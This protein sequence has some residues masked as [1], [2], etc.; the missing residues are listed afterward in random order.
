MK[1]AALQIPGAWVIDPDLLGDERGFFARTFCRKEFEQHGL[2]GDLA[3]CNVSFNRKRGTL[4]GMHYQREPHQEAKL[5]R[6]TQG[7]I[8]DVVLDLRPDSP[9]YLGWHAI[10]LN[11]A[12]RRMLYVPEG[13]AHGFM[14]LA[15]E[16]EV[17][18]QMAEF[19]HPEC[20]AGVRWDDP[21]FGIRWPFS[22]PIASAKDLSYPRFEKNT[23]RSIG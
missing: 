15:D 6:C 12:N 23:E 16:S 18:Y 4:R 8:Y 13:C 10:E 1:F 19:Y 5:V 9:A 21:A 2:S 11:A 20:S 17:F 14:T 22:E 7:A 3:Q